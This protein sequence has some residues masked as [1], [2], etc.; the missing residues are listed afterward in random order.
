ML[1]VRKQGIC[2]YVV[3][4]GPLPELVTAT[5]GPNGHIDWMNCGIND[6][7]WDP[8]L[9]K[10]SD[11]VTLDLT[12]AM[13]NPLSPFMD[14]AEYIPLFIKYGAETGI[15]PIMLA[16]FAMQESSCDAELVGGAG[17]QGLMQL[18]EDKCGKA[19]GGNCKDPEYNI[20]TGARY[21]KQNLD[22]SD[23]DVLKSIGAY[24]GWYD[25]MTYSSATAAQYSGN[26]YTQQNLDYLH[27]FLNGWCQNVNSYTNR[28]KLG[29]YFNL[30]K[31]H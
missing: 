25:G 17:E 9:V 28:P 1:P 24:N 8:P 19:P 16:S 30:D 5:S 23:G 21:F 14:C 31:C 20:A 7:G 18:T 4:D 13:K 15:P 22:D 26:C 2:P 6:R 29:K 12:E 10:L 27:Q 11:L 3:I